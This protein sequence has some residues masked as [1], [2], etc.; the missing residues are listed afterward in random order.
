MFPDDESHARNVF[1]N[2][3]MGLSRDQRAVARDILK[4]IDDA[5]DNIYRENYVLTC[6]TRTSLEVYSL[7]HHGKVLTMP[8]APSQRIIRRAVRREGVLESVHV[9][10]D[11]GGPWFRL[12]LTEENFDKITENFHARRD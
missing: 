10:H 2:M 8:M 12:V 3:F 6:H 1:Q 11:K 9:A 5:Q 4:E 7:D